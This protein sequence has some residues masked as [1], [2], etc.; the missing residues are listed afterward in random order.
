MQ[1]RQLEHR[2]RYRDLILNHF[3]EIALELVFL[4]LALI[5]QFTSVTNTRIGR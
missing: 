4:T 3:N 2:I 1:R 5:Y